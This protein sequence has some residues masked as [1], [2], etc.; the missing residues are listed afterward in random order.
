M[1]R[2]HSTHNGVTNLTQA[3][4]WGVLLVESVVLWCQGPIPFARSVWTEHPAG[5]RLSRFSEDI[6]VLD[7][8]VV[9]ADRSPVLDIVDLF[10]CVGPHGVG[11]N[12]VDSSR[13]D[14]HAD[15]G[16]SPFEAGHR[17]RQSGVRPQARAVP[18]G[19]VSSRYSADVM[20][21]DGVSSGA[22]GHHGEVGNKPSSLAQLKAALGYFVAFL[23]G[24]VASL[25]LRQCL[26]H[27]RKL[28]P[29]G[30]HVNEREQRDNARE[31]G[32]EFNGSHVSPRH[33]RFG[34]VLFVSGTLLAVGGVTSWQVNL[35]LPLLAIPGLILG[36][37]G[38]NL[39]HFGTVRLP[40]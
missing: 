37:I 23:C 15:V 10:V 18:D 22:A 3:M 9:V 20:K 2:Y 13:T 29:S 7:L 24:A 11:R 6:R 34:Q 21:L 25:C 8:A 36:I 26:S 32:S 38:A 14:N 33:R 28:T 40:F 39:W 1:T 4:P 16:R 19:D 27:C 30:P 35:L 31:D 17:F 5:Y 12:Q